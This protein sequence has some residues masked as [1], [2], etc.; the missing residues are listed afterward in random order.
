LNVSTCYNITHEEKKSK[1]N[2]I[3]Y[4]EADG[5]ENGAGLVDQPTAAGY[6]IIVQQHRGEIKAETEV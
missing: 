6:E 3:S 1:F 2:S 4:H 5:T